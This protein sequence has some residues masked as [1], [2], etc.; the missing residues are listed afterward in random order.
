MEKE[1][2]QLEL[3]SHSG[4]DFE[5]KPA[6]KRRL[7]VSWRG[8]EKTIILAICF[9]V[10]SAVSFS[11]GME[12]GKR[13][14]ALRTDSKLDLASPVKKELAPVQ[15]AVQK[16]PEPAVVLRS[17]VLNVT[18]SIY[19][20]QLAT[21]KSRSGADKEAELLRKKGLSPLVLVKSGYFVLYASNFKDKETAKQTQAE[22]KKRYKDCIIRRL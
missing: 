10:T 8:H 1:H 18:G 20:I 4:G 14:A 21:Y 3:F 19:A 9:M 6:Q 15:I 13:I 22:L 17:Q 5:S 11:L 2:T 12:R 16:A 7:F